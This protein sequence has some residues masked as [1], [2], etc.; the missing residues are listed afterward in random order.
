MTLEERLQIERH[1]RSLLEQE[2]LAKRLE[3]QSR[4]YE[5][6]IQFSN[7][8]NMSCV[9][10]WN[11]AN[12]PVEKM[13]PGLLAK[14]RRQIAPSL[15]V[16]IPYDGSEPL[17]LTWDQARDLAEQYSIELRITTNTQFLDA[18][19]FGELKDITETLFLSIDS[20]DR[21]IFKKLRPGGKPDV[22]FEN[23]ATTAHLS[24]EHELE[25]LASIVFM[26]PNAPM[27]PE[28][29]SYLADVGIQSVNVLQLIDVNGQ[30]EYLDPLVHFSAEYV[31]WI[32]DQCIDVAKSKRTRLI[33]NVAGYERHDFRT[34]EEKIPPK[35]RK[36]W[37]HRW[38]QRMKH[39]VPGY[40][41][42]VYNRLQ[43]HANGRVDPCAYATDDELTYG[44]LN[45]QDF[46]EIW[47]GPNARDLR[48]AMA[49]WDYPTLCA[50][51]MFTNRA[52]AEPYLPF[53]ADVLR[54]LD[55][56][57]CAA[58]STLEASSPDHMA[59]L[60]DAPTFSIG[61][62]QE[63]VERYVLA[64]AL[65]GEGDE[66]ELCEP[67]P[68]ESDDDGV[69]RFALPSGVWDRL[70]TNLG[71]WWAVFGISAE[72]PNRVLRTS[73]IRCVVRHEDIPRVEG[74]T[75]RYADQGFLPVVDLGGNKQA[76]WE[77]RAELPQRP[78]LQSRRHPF[79]APPATRNGADRVSATDDVLRATTREKGMSK[80]RYRRL[81]GEI[82]TMVAEVL[83]EDA[84]VAV[85]SKGDDALLELDCSE[86]WHFPHDEDGRYVGYHPPN[87]DWA[88][89]H[90]EATRLKGA[91]YLLIP[92]CSSWWFEHYT[93]FAE[94]LWKHHPVAADVDDVC[95]IFAVG[96][97][98]A[99][100][101]RER[102]AKVNEHLYSRNG[103]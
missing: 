1:N 87:S 29:I 78:K 23:L 44:D 70:R 93:G 69:L 97:F 30:S 2:L 91:D 26:T 99:F 43:V 64:L 80:E 66:V 102:D 98:P 22:I 77:V 60:A 42:N 35:T 85:L 75:L 56:P 36:D 50:S 20:H 58:Q 19:R 13:S 32:K 95:T 9:M 100:Y 16:V 4:P 72:H 11:G 39:L 84:T 37:N 62:P 25:T 8:C 15:S 45:T 90:L 3:F 79:A 96:P 28:T 86:A 24:K 38:D 94:H 51:C 34:R 76:G 88:I 52:P 10:C 92:A 74:S 46:D 73:E 65:G 81:V 27:L 33:W 18:K 6:H 67:E 83:P 12:P 17:V 55:K 40:C 47:N 101:G 48:R 68:I 63:E 31:A 7:F 49:T 53:V 59:R 54:E 21:E 41:M 71:Y 5:A 82:R 61:R 14:V 57:R 89:D 103:R